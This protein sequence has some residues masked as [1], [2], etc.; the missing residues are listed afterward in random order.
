MYVDLS[1][2][3]I[4][5]QGFG[6]FQLTEKS[7]AVQLEYFPTLFHACKPNINIEKWSRS[8]DCRLKTT[9]KIKMHYCLEDATYPS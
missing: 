1:T 5:T 4:L 8:R 3:Y 7:N 2:F 9:G 6:E